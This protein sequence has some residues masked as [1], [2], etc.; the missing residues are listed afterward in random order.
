M[1]ASRVILVALLS[2]FA[3][4]AHAH[5]P[6]GGAMP[7]TLINGLLS[8]FGHPVI[9]PDHL[10]F[11]LALG[12]TATLTS[13]GLAIP[14][15]FI[16]AS[17]MGVLIH[18]ANLL[19]PLAEPL[20]A[21]TLLGV[22]AIFMTGRQLPNSIWLTV[23]VLSGIVHGY[24]FGEAIIG[25]ERAVIGAYLLGLAIV[26]FALAAGMAAL[27]RA[28]LQTDGFASYRLKAAGGALV[29]MGLLFLGT[30]GLPA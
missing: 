11:I 19:I 5:H 24:A 4:A 8:G 21:A 18:A 23:A 10:M 28:V 2:L 27:A 26:Q 20:V 30:S 14:L 3:S 25:A 13:T 22:G 29:A 17:T 6:L 16:A 9:G 12:V 15:A 1:P 7:E